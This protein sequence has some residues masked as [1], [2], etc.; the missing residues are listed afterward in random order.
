MLNRFFNHRTKSITSAAIILIAATFL[1][2]IVGLLR[3]RILTSTFGASRSLDIYWAAFRIPDLL[4]NILILGALTSALIPMFAQLWEKKSSEVA[5]RF[6]NN[7]L[8][9]FILT[10]IVAGILLFIFAPQLMKMVVPGFSGQEMQTVVLLTRIMFLSPL[11]LTISNIFGA[12]LQ[13]FSK[14]LVYSFAPILYNLGIIVGAVFFVPKYGVV[15]LAWGVVLGAFLHLLIQI[16]P[17]LLSK[18]RFRP[19]VDLGDKNLRQTIKLMLPMTVGVAASQVN[20]LIITAI[21]SLLTA[22]SIAI[23]TLSND[24]QFVPISLFGISF[25][26]AAFPVLSRAFS[27][28][29]KNK[30]TEK[31]STTFSQIIFFII[32]VSFLFFILRAQIVRVLYG[33]GKF[34]WTDTRLTAAC[35]AAF[36]LSIFAQGLI[37]LLNQAFYSAHNAKTPVKI[38]IFSIFFNIIFSF[39]FVY[40]IAKIPNI[41]NFFRFFFK[42]QGIEN[43][44]VIGLPLAFSLT[45]ILNLMWLIR[46]FKKKV[47]NGWDFKLRDSFLRIFLL[48]LSCGAICYILLYL[49]APLFS[50][51]TFSGIF[52]QGIFAGG[53]TIILY[54]YLAKKFRFPEYN[55]ITAALIKRVSRKVVEVEA[56]I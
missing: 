11:I 55:F 27:S 26:V 39:S 32:P 15:G 2:K 6:L 4:F 8:C 34:T 7:I 12:L 30:F 48:S 28:G 45:S 10:I 29:E 19:I 50:L 47:G 5:W 20:L 31:F 49:F 46:A 22:G 53:I 42:L 38:N 14:F 25:A 1:S 56:E 44:S 21:A 36:S 13:Y 23:F 43:I 16:P 37:P 18:F 51:E 17:V 33:A 54:L 3:N 52:F 40:L 24:L 41:T 9:V 35:L